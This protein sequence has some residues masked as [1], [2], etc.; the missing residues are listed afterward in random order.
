MSNKVLYV[1]FNT[2]RTCITVGT[3]MGFFAYD[4]FPFKRKCSHCK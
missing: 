3:E 1:G 2:D 4:M